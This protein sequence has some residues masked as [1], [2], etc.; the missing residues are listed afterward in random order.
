MRRG[1][2]LPVFLLG[3]VLSGCAPPMPRD[4][5][6]FAVA[7]V[8]PAV[9]ELSIP[10]LLAPVDAAPVYMGKDM[11]YRLRYGDNKLQSYSDNRWN[12]PPILMLASVLRQA[13]GKNLLTLEQSNQTARCALHIGLNAFEQVFIDEQNSHIELDLQ[14][15]LIQ[16]RNK[17]ELG[18]GK[19]HFDIPA[20]TPDAR[21]GALALEMASHQAAAQI[22]ER[23][24]NLLVPLVSGANPIRAACVR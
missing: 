5:T 6:V 1:V 4:I 16:L 2:L 14:F 18:G 10:L 21:G 24:N 20:Q 3:F 15:S 9:Q 7:P 8:Q 19:L 12:M 13:G 23:M 11:L 22:V 17:R